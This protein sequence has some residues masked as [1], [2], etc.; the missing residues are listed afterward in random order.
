MPGGPAPRAAS[1]WPSVEVDP[2]RIPALSSVLAR[3]VPL[4]RRLETFRLPAFSS[5]LALQAVGTIPRRRDR[6]VSSYERHS[7]RRLFSH[8]PRS[9]IGER[10]DS[11]LF[12]PRLQRLHPVPLTAL[13]RVCKR[14]DHSYCSAYGRP[15]PSAHCSPDRLQD[16]PKGVK[17]RTSPLLLH[18]TSA[19]GTSC[20]RICR[21]SR[22]EV[23][24]VPLLDSSYSAVSTGYES[25][26]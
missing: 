19:P 2:P 20:L 13:E 6:V 8:T 26:P 7:P 1:R 25:L 10:C 11:A 16:C 3:G 9:V 22:H 15:P 14:N 4:A 21:C 23:C 18:T 12:F 24:A 17:R 5:F